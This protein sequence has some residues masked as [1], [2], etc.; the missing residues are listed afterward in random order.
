MAETANT[1]TSMIRVPLSADEFKP[2][3]STDLVTEM[4]NFQRSYYEELRLLIQ[5]VSGEAESVHGSLPFD[6]AALAFKGQ[7]LAASNGYAGIA[8]LQAAEFFRKFRY[9]W[10][11]NTGHSMLSLEKQRK[12]LRLE[13]KGK[14]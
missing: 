8:D 9:A 4:A 5:V 6:E 10:K 12:R 1:G 11:R 13:H 3:R 14:A 2:P 7:E